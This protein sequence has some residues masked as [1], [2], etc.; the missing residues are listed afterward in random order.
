MPYRLFLDDIRDPPRDG[1]EWVIARSFE[2]AVAIVT[3]HGYPTF[4][5]FDHDLGDNVPTGKDFANWLVEL[6][7]AEGSMPDD[8]GFYVHSANPT[9]AENIRGHLEQYVRIRNQT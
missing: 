3:E 4:I 9:G 8:F 6:D 7:L 5:S 2:E 1:G